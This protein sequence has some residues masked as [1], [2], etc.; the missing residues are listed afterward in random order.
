MT[1]LGYLVGAYMGFPTAY[2]HED[3]QALH[4]IPAAPV[5]IDADVLRSLAP[6]L[7]RLRNHG[8]AE[9]EC[10]THGD[11]AAISRHGYLFERLDTLVG[12]NA[13][14]R[15]LMDRPAH[16]A[17]FW[18]QVND[19]R[20]EKSGFFLIARKVRVTHYSVKI[21]EGSI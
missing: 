12:V 10:L 14:G 2:L 8:D 6:L 16:R 21:W 18:Q 7:R 5:N 11:R 9:W 19:R 17:M 15:F 3:H 13:F 1:S 4:E 20:Q